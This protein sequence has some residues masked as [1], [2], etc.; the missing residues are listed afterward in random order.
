MTQQEL[1]TE[2]IRVAADVARGTYSLDLSDCKN[3]AQA[4]RKAFTFDQMRVRLTERLKK[5]SEESRKL[6]VGNPFCGEYAGDVIA[7]ASYFA[8]MLPKRHPLDESDPLKGHRRGGDCQVHGRW[9]GE[10]CPEW[11][12]C[13]QKIME[14]EHETQT[15]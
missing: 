7:G 6:E 3:I 14:A 9:I 11:P 4:Q 10:Q 5:L 2:L 8:C 1:T 13:V 12:K 15:R